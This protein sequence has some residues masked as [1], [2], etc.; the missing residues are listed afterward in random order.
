MPVRASRYC[1]I[2]KSLPLKAGEGGGD[3]EAAPHYDFAQ[4]VAA[5]VARYEKQ[6]A[7]REE[8]EEAWSPLWAPAE[9]ASVGRPAGPDY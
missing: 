3:Q 8:G 4:L 6:P 1:R 5:P 2:F 9:D 7:C